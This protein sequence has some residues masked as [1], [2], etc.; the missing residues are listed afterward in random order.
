[1]AEMT[2][3]VAYATQEEQVEHEVVVP[4]HANVAIAIRASGLLTR[5]PDWELG[6][7]DVG[8]FGEIRPLD[9]PLKAG[10]R[11]EIYRPLT[12]DP[13]TRRRLRAKK[14]SGE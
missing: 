10:D 8:V 2:V 13:M 5:Y 7:L 1:M 6:E 12:I 3:K 9:H 14:R 4:V 11:V